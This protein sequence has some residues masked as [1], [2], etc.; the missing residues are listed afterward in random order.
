MHL[1][2]HI[3]YVSKFKFKEYDM[4]RI[5]CQNFIQLL[6]VFMFFSNL[7]PIPAAAYQVTCKRIYNE[8]IEDYLSPRSV[9]KVQSAM[10]RY[11]QIL[12]FETIDHK[13]DALDQLKL[14]LKNLSPE[15]QLELRQLIADVYN[16]VKALKYNNEDSFKSFKRHI[17]LI[18]SEN[19]D[20]H[21]FFKEHIYQL[22]LSI[23]KTLDLYFEQIQKWTNSPI[24]NKGEDV[25]LTA[26]RLQHKILPQDGYSRGPLILYGSFVNGKAYTKSSDLDF[27]VLNTRLESQMKSL[28][29]LPELQEFPLS[30]AQAHVIAPTQIHGLGYMNPIVILVY[31]DYISVRVYKS[32]SK[33]S[34]KRSPQFEEFFF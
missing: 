22:G 30:E 20:A 25:L 5:L 33:N 34:Y 19:I 24:L 14:K 31:R 1:N 23:E 16:E 9:S 12:D 15:K 11:K 3:E 32:L 29:L 26:M 8:N 2:L 4:R 7:A 28:D 6:S 18:V 17:D 27:A 10:L 21:R 13:A